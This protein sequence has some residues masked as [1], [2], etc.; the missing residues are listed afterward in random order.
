MTGASRGFSR[1]AAPVW[2]FS[3]GTMGSSGSLSCGAGEV[4]S[5][6]A[7][8]GGA[9]HFS[10]VMVGESGLKT[11]EE[12]LARFF[13]GYGR[14]PWV[15]ST[16]A[17]DLRELFRVPLRSQGYY[18]AGRGLSGLHWVCCN[19]RGPNL[20]IRKEPQGSS[21]FL[22]QIAGSLQSWDRRVRPRL[23]WRNGTPLASRVVQGVTGH[24]SSCV[25]NLRFFPDTARGFQ[26]PFVMCFHPQGCLRS[27]V[28]AS[29]S[30]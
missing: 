27:G 15:P 26:C 12:G 19:G 18:G 29:G 20:E 2:G 4:R 28:R 7:W 5:S 21:P 11:R 14:K 22:T 13:S 8:R 10:P 23:V 3:R 25:W 9:R 6:C 30:Y 1:A 17:R 16:Y 24:L